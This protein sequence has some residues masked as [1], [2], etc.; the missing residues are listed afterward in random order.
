MTFKDQVAADLPTFLNV[1]EFGDV[2]D[3]DGHQVACVQEGNGDTQDSR[4]G[5]TNVD[6]VLFAMAS[7][8]YRVPVVGQRITVDDRPADVVA[9]SEDQGMLTIRL[10][11][12]DS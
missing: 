8:F 3:I 7:A 10:R 4:E 1:E 11:W 6:T 12:W 2:V 9:I 5:V